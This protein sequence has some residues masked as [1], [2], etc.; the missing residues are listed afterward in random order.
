MEKRNL[1]LPTMDELRKDEELS[2][3]Q[4]DLM[5]L[6][7]QSP[8]VSW[9]KPHPTAKKK[10]EV[11]GK[12]EPVKY[13][14][15]ER[16]EWLM[17]RIFI[18]WRCEVTSTQLIGNSVV[19]AVRVHY[20]YPITGEWDWTDG[21]GASPLQTD[22]GAGAID[23][24][25][26]KSTAVQM[27]APSAKSYAFKDACECLGKI[28]GKDLNRRDIDYNSLFKEREELREKV[29]S[30]PGDQMDETLFNQNQ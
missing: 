8:P 12:Y 18:R 19:V 7:N 22:S 15:V 29:H 14:P 23:F 20:I 27:A 13:L 1:K 21:V 16:V 9:A 28:F 11:T 10:D 30:T 26:L 3:K 4:N 17:S 2:L 6:L 24:N 5:V 25:K